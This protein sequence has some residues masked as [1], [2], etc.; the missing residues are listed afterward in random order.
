MNDDE[1]EILYSNIGAQISF[2]EDE[3]RI[4]YRVKNCFS[5]YNNQI[6]TVL[7]EEKEEITFKKID[8]EP[9]FG[10]LVE[11]KT[12]TKDREPSFNHRVFELAEDVDLRKPFEYTRTYHVDSEIKTMEKAKQYIRSRKGGNK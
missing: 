11:V 5:K 10:I 9:G 4:K 6:N 8:L 7:D 3:V 2:E 12:E 1:K